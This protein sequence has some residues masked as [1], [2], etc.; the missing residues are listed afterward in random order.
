MWVGREMFKL[1]P[2]AATETGQRNQEGGLPT[3]WYLQGPTAS[4]GPSPVGK[5][6]SVE[7]EQPP[8]GSISLPS[9]G[10]GPNSPELPFGQVASLSLYF[11][12]NIMG[13]I[14]ESTNWVAVLIK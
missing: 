10:Q 12:I 5:Y 1:W 13:I 9:W 11:L 6:F 14:M 2:G 3:H 7:V 8:G 4:L